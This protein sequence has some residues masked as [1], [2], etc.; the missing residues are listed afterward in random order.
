MLN[1]K[2]RVLECTSHRVYKEIKRFLCISACSCKNEG[3]PII[4]DCYRRNYRRRNIFILKSFYPD[5]SV[6]LNIEQSSKCKCLTNCCSRKC[7]L[8]T[9]RYFD[10]SS[11][12][13]IPVIFCY[14]DSL[15]N[16]I[17]RSC[18]IHDETG[19]FIIKAGRLG[20]GMYDKT[21]N[22]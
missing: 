13:K 7:S 20:I 16:V 5:E 1:S 9:C 19:Q 6:G 2:W 15:P 3:V 11:F 12:V 4:I 8:C 18:L 17:I 22:E 21:H 14:D 10:I